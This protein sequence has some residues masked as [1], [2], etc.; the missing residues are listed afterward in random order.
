M[1]VDHRTYTTHPGKIP[2]F[3]EVYGKMGYPLQ[4]KFLGDCR[5]WYFSMDI[6]ELNQ[7]VHLWGYKDIADRATRRAALNADP[8]WQEYLKAALPLLQKME[9]KIVTPAPFYTPES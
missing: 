9:N 3:L 8:E 1:I 2:D 6:G 4:M 5:G 7:V